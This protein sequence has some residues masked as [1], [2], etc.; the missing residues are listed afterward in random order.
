MSAPRRKKNPPRIHNEWRRDAFDRLEDC[1][2]AEVE[3]AIVHSEKAVDPRRVPIPRDIR[4]RLL[5]DATLAN[6]VW[7]DANTNQVVYS[8][9]EPEKE[10]QGGGRGDENIR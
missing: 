4:Y 10:K 8:T 3:Q 7:Y 5:K 1:E 9:R 2:M 6:D